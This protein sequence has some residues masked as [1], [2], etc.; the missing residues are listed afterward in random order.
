M[1][2]HVGGGGGGYSST[3]QDK[4]RASDRTLEYSGIT[5]STRDVY[6]Y[7]ILYGSTA[8]MYEAK[9]GSSTGG[10]VGVE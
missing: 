8:V 10:Y 9:E 2:K 6:E 5:K 7:R 1:R 3:E 4:R